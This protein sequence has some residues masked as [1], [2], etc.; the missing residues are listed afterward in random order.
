MLQSVGKLFR[1]TDHPCL[2]HRLP[3]PG[4]SRFLVIALESTQTGDQ[5]SL[6]SG[7]SQAGVDL[8]DRA[9][10]GHQRKS[11]NNPLR[12]LGEVLVIAQLPETRRVGSLKRP[13]LSF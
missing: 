6:V 9:F 4:L 7:W 8:I 11:G 12:Q 1:T 2:G 13:G 3:L 5:R 10:P